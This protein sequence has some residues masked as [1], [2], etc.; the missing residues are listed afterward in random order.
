MAEQKLPKLLTS[1][2]FCR[3][4]RKSLPETPFWFQNHRVPGAKQNWPRQTV[5]R[6]G[7]PT[8]ME[9][10][11]DELASIKRIVRREFR[12]RPWA[13][14]PNVRAIRSKG[15]L[16][17]YFNSGGS[18][19]TYHR[20]PDPDSPTFAT[21]YKALVDAH[22]TGND[23]DRVSRRN[24][25]RSKEPKSVVYF[26]GSE[27]GPIKIGCALN[28]NNR[29]A[30][31]QCASPV[32]LAILATTPGRTKVERAYHARFAAHRLHGEWFAPHPDIL[33][34]IEHLQGAG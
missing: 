32:R 31:L 7:L 11:M 1:A 33:T 17:L 27:G 6:R 22:A 8:G 18:A 5:I 20:L 29:L 9:R 26:I 12:D 34:E 24:M 13:G 10:R 21:A 2:K 3:S 28:V 14:L 19:R 30:A 4:A 16:Y 23:L 25:A 15:R